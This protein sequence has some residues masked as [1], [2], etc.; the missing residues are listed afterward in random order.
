MS[1]IHL[2]DIRQGAGADMNEIIRNAL[3]MSASLVEQL[4]ESDEDDESAGGFTTPRLEHLIREAVVN[5]KPQLRERFSVK[6]KR[7]ANQR[8]VTM[9]FLGSNLAANFGVIFPMNLSANVRDIKSKLWDLANLREE[10]GRKSLF[11]STVH[12]YEM[13]VY[14][15]R[16]DEPVFSD[17][18]LKSIEEAA[19]ELETEA[20]DMEVICRTTTDHTSIAR[21]ILEAEAA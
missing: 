6:L 2:G 9:G 10:P 4:A 1:G 7:A 11:P 20:D 3:V 8:P 12:Q 13:H 14:R 17:R 18:Q 21:R 16:P 19:N 5:V 15:P